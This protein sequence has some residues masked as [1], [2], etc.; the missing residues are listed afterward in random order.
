[1]D[2][3]NAD[4]KLHDRSAKCKSKLQSQHIDLHANKSIC[5]PCIVNTTIFLGSQEVTKYSANKPQ[6]YVTPKKALKGCVFT[7]QFPI[8]F[9]QSSR[10]IL[11]FD[12]NATPYRL[13]LI[14]G[15]VFAFI[16]VR[17]TSCSPNRYKSENSA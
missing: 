4:Q 17:Q 16:T 9:F 10:S 15:R 7:V 13:A 3:Q 5:T 12:T 8:F 1:M 14:P 11:F 2:L 6:S